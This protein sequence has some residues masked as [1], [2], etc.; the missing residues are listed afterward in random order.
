MYT[1]ARGV[2]PCFNETPSFW[3]FNVPK[4]Q[5]VKS[6]KY[7]TYIFLY[8]DDGS[9]K[10][11]GLLLLIAKLQFIVLKILEFKKLSNLIKISI[12]YYCK[13]FLEIL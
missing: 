11:E 9:S 2:E 10:S 12:L 8:F 4:R 1:T 13:K 3:R 6:C 7:L 5:I